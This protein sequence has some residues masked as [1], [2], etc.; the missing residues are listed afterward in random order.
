MAAVGDVFAFKAGGKWVPFQLI[1]TRASTAPGPA[2]ERRFAAVKPATEAA[3]RKCVLATNEHEG[4]IHTIE[5]E[6]LSD[7]LIAIAARN[8]LPR[9][10]AAAVIDA[11]RDW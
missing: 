10:R 1:G 7:K 11:A 6:E 4:E 3:L 5:A 8:E 9:D 2:W